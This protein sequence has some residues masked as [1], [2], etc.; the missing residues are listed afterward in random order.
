MESE[1][2]NNSP[3]TAQEQTEVNV[4]SSVTEDQTKKK[5]RR[6]QRPSKK[7]RLAQNQDENNQN[8]QEEPSENEG[9]AKST[10]PVN[11]DQGT[12]V[13]G[14]TEDQTKKKRRQKQ[15]PPKKYRL[16]Q[17]QNESSQNA[18]A[19]PG[20]NEETAKST[21]PVDD[22]N[23]E[24]IQIQ[25]SNK[26]DESKPTRRGKRSG[27]KA[28]T[29]NSSENNVPEEAVNEAKK[30]PKKNKKKVK[31]SSHEGSAANVSESDKIPLSRTSKK[32]PKKSAR[33][34]KLVGSENK[35]K[36][37][38]FPEFYMPEVVEHA[39]ANGVLLSGTLR[40]HT[41]NFE[42]AYISAP[43]GSDDI[44]I[45]GVRNRNRA[46]HGDKVAVDIFPESQWRING[47]RLRDYNMMNESTLESMLNGM[48][49]KD[50]SIENLKE[51]YPDNWQQFVQKT[52]RVVAIL[53]WKHSRCSAGYLKLFQ[54]K[55][56]QFALFSPLDSRFPR[57]K[58][59][60][61]CCPADFFQ[62][63]QEFADFIFIAALDKWDLVNFAMGHLTH[64]L[65]SDQDINVRTQAILM[66]NGV[67]YPDD[68]SQHIE[69]A[70]P[71]LPFIIPPSEIAQR[72]DFRSHCVFTIDPLTARD[73]DDALSIEEMDNGNFKVGVHIA[74]VAYFVSPK[75]ALDSEASNRATSVY[76]VQKVV[77]ML[78]RTLCEHLCSLNPG[79]D[80]LTFSVEWVLDDQG[81]VLET[82]FGRSVI[83][84]AVKLAYEHAQEM[85]DF[86]DKEWSEGELPSIDQPWTV[87]VIS[88]KVN[89]LQKL[90][91]HLRRKRHDNGALRLDQP[92]LSFSLDKESGLPQGYK[93]YEQRQSNRLIEEFMLLAN[94]SVAEKIHA[95]FPEIAVL[96]CHPEPKQALM[97][98]SIKDLH[99]FNIHL[100]CATS[101]TLQASINNYRPNG[102]DDLQGAGRWQVL[103]NVL[104]RPMQNARYFCTGMCDNP[105]N[106][107][108][109][110]L[111][112]PLYT[113]FTSP[114]RRYPDILV[115][116]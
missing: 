75:T 103:M 36:D 39:L 98:R 86:P 90:A 87:Q 48:T 113:H 50:Q 5:R 94:I 61:K 12:S 23:Q 38:K 16:A 84:S 102:E 78:P 20:E 25:D 4:S 31:A 45:Q 42:E 106:F 19:P 14:V 81:N 69:D 85:L 65:G 30:S 93:V 64:N 56:P 27:K 18:Q 15:R 105:E 44:S 40:I 32:S 107:R 72:R 49:L 111:S 89:L 43:N 95:C 8:V 22:S 77:P 115:H 63:P 73:L 108:H 70:L 6:R 52:G 13:S 7:H 71:K 114:I 33:K 47:E 100:D 26:N 76:L 58:I 59:P 17:K 80:R 83:R 9:T 11:C 110:A 35:Q 91:V 60:Q 104:S 97:L 99:K 79:Q 10:S 96:R 24:A 74:D 34:D 68:F 3:E 92:K 82:W 109:Y 101:K 21:S 67:D 62:R 29:P 37:G 54:D 88:H 28:K 2:A 51:A 55:N 41:K 57:M 46:L 116:R 1:I 112:V 66:E 53:E